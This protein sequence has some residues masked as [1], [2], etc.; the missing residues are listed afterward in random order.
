MTAALSV[1]IRTRKFVDDAGARG[2]RIVE[3]PVNMVPAQTAVILCDVWDRHWCPTAQERLDAMVPG[4]NQLVAY[5]REQDVL[6]VHSPS[7]TMGYYADHPA[8]QRISVTDPVAALAKVDAP[9]L[10]VHIGA[11]QGCDASV[12]V[13]PESVWTRQHP[14]IEIDEQRDVISDDGGEL[15]HAFRRRGISTVMLMGV[16]TNMCILDRSFGIRALVGY[17]FRTVLIRDLTDAMYDPADP[18]YVSH[19]EGTSLIVDYIEKF[20]CGTTVG[21]ALLG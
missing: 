11:T 10:P 5:L 18:P 20:L 1:V 8:R 4:M 6:I 12:A 15:A 17:G 13:R 3:T 19:D 2:W 7:E 14:G 21:A 16:H 9:E